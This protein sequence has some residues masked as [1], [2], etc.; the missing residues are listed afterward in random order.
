MLF[1]KMYVN[2]CMS[3]LYLCMCPWPNAN[4]FFNKET[5]T[6]YSGQ[7]SIRDVDIMAAALTASHANAEGNKRYET[8]SSKEL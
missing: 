3:L 5:V 1:C 2:V 7:L 4:I 8:D 6:M